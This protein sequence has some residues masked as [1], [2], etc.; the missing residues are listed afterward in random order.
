MKN[1]NKESKILKVN[2]TIAIIE[3]LKNDKNGNPV[4]QVQFINLN[5]LNDG[6]QSL[7]NTTY[8]N[9]YF[10]IV[11]YNIELDVQNIIKERNSKEV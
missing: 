7:Y 11:S 6:T 4:F 2:E 10:R 8:N 3:R 9:E 1:I 5:T